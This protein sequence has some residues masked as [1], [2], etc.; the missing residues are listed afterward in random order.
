MA[1]ASTKDIKDMKDNKTH[2]GAGAMK[3][4]TSEKTKDA[5]VHADE[6]T[7]AMAGAQAGEKPNSNT[8]NALAGKFHTFKKAT[9]AREWFILSSLVS[10]DFKLKYRRSV[11]GVVWSILNPL[12][13]MCVL[14]A[15]FSYM[16]KFNIENF[17]LYLIL[18]TTLFN[19]MSDATTSAMNSILDSAPL[20]KKIRINKIIFPLEKVTFALL[21]FVISLIAVAIVICYF[22]IIPTINIV[23]VPLLLIYL[24]MFSLGIGL[25]LAAGAVFFRDFLHLWGVLV[26]AWTYA[27]PLFYPVDMLEPWM[28]QIM[29][30]NPMYYYVNYFRE[31]LLYGTMPSLTENAICLGCGVVFLLLGL[32]VFKKQQNKF[33]L[34]V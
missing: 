15:V 33:I 19:F 26:T 34:Y 14:T 5:N 13:M 18:G 2:V 32:L 16:F 4:E 10:R 27:T 17:P 3:S 22:R 6:K 28:I 8:Q 12:L 11:L 23:F 1:D 24:F 29:N 21:N 31:C 9:A 7:E 30:F 25:L 20:I